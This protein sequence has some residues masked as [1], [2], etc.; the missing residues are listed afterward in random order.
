MGAVLCLARSG[1]LFFLK[2]LSQ[3][4]CSQKIKIKQNPKTNF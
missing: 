2:R 4:Y 3:P 1:A